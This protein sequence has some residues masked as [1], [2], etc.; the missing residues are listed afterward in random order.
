M[1]SYAYAYAANLFAAAASAHSW[2]G[3][4][5]HDNT[6]ILKWMEG[7]STLTPPVTIDPLMPWFSNFCKGW[8]RAKSNPGDWIA[9][10]SNYVWNIPAN[11]F[12]GD[13]HACH[14]NQ[15]GPNYE[16]NAPMATATPGGSLRL[17]FGGNGHARGSNVGGDPGVV[18]VYWKGEPEAEIIDISEFTEENKLQEGGFS[19]ESFAYPAGAMSPTEGLQDKGNWQTIKL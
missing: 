1:K 8:P 17:M 18:T 16:G 2:L 6:E 12:N 3:C 10:S 9:E 5:D 13:T 19:A 4:T 15:R 14:P 11:S 7:N